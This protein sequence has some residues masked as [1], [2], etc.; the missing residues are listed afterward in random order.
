MKYFN[1][2]AKR[3]PCF[4]ADTGTDIG[5]GTETGTDIDNNTSLFSDDDS[6]NTESSESMD[7]ETEESTD[8]TDDNTDVNNAD[9]NK[10]K[11]D[12]QK[13]KVKYNGEEIELTLD[14][15]IVHTQKG[16]NYDK[17]LAQKQALEQSKEFQ[18]LDY[19][20][21]L[22]GMTRQ[23]YTDYLIESKE[24]QAL[25]SEVEAV[26]SKYA[27]LPDELA[28][29]IAQIRLE[30]NKS[31]LAEKQALEE[32]QKQESQQK[33][34]M[35]FMA[36]YPDIKPEQIPEEVWKTVSQGKDLL[37]SYTAWEN[38]QLKEKLQTLEHNNKIKSKSIGSATGDGIS[39]DED[40]FLKG[41]F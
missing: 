26:K 1:L 17:V 6:L 18:I 36:T 16:M 39:K 2:F 10:Q 13:Y 19:Y 9:A 14:E 4:N 31:K 34:Y 27:D 32:K 3:L 28:E 21:S 12:E 33:Q 20:A 29:E 38:K 11:Q 15:M 22:Q 40:S 30:Q 24:K 5:G 35:E 25:I 41:L 7:T 23:Q 8:N 37:S